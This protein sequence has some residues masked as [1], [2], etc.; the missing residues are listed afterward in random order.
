MLHKIINYV[1]EHA[2]QGLN[3]SEEEKEVIFFGITRIIE[4]IPK[5]ILIIIVGAFLNIILEILIVTIVIVLY[6]TFVGGMHL[7]TNIACFIYSLSSYLITIYSS[8]LIKSWGINIYFLAFLNY[9]FSIYII[10]RYAPADVENIPKIN[11]KLRKT[12]KIQALISLNI[13]YIFV[14]FLQFDFINYISKII[15]INSIFY[16]NISTT[17]LFYKIFNVKYGFLNKGKEES[18][19]KDTCKNC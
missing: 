7:E 13:I 16:I 14:L 8:F 15:V 11:L 3:K 2:T 6:K 1:F 17:K 19:E 10:L 9:V 4:D 18:Y 12:L 5:A